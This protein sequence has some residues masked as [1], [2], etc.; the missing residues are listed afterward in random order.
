[1]DQSL[2][3][4]SPSLFPLI[5]GLLVAAAILS[6][7]MWLIRRRRAA[8]SVTSRLRQASDGL[9]AGVLIP[10]ADAGQIHIDYA[11]LTRQGIVLVDVRD[12]TGHVFGSETMQ[13]WTVLERSQR[14][15]FSNPLPPLYDRV[16]AVKR[17]LPTMPVRG[18]VAFTSRA[19][20]SKGFPPNVVMLDRL[21]DDL[22]A[23]RRSTDGPAPELLQDGWAQLQ[24]EAARSRRG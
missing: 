19:D 12:V 5:M 11:V 9:L 14:F 7:V 3:Q 8:R 22:A 10:N 13:D 23:M 6:A 20:F 1:M 18:V 17:M 4:S 21:L 16:A 2:S 24:R 15:T